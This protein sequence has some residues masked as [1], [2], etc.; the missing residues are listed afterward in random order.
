MIVILGI[1]A[2]GLYGARTARSRGGNRKDIAQFAAVGGIVG[3]LIGL[4][5]T[6]GLER[7]L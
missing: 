2:G 1:L 7:V 6:I 3:G 5:A 4:F